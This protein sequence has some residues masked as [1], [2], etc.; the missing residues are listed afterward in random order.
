MIEIPFS[1]TAG[2]F[3][4]V[5][6]ALGSI[7]LPAAAQG[8]AFNQLRMLAGAASG[9][10]EIIDLG[11]VG[12]VDGGETVPEDGVMELPRARSLDPSCICPSPECE[13]ACGRISQTPAYSVD[14]AGIV[15]RHWRHAGKFASPPGETFLSV[16]FNAK[17]DAYLSVLPPGWGDPLFYKFRKGMAGAWKF[18]NGD[19]YRVKLD[20][21]IFRSKTSN[22]V[23]VKKDGVEEPVYKERI[24]TLLWQAYGAGEPVS[25]NGREYRL[26]YSNAIRKPGENEPERIIPDEFSI[27]L[28]HNA[29]DKD[30]PD[31]KNYMIPAKR[32][33]G[34]AVVS[35]E[36]YDGQKVGLR[37]PA[38][39]KTLELFDEKALGNS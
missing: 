38:G 13:A 19:I 24:K 10:G 2:G 30:D 3:L 12:P 17:G 14:L 33:E 25:L 37:I 4:T 31:I 18:R 28:I 7:P 16:H 21:N 5:V 26:F 29:G 27:V 8:L 11:P 20:V 39:T 15:N 23:V 22:Y 35:Y 1:R 6:L 9:G 34:T 36:L 32:I